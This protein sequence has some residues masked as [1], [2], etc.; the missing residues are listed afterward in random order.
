MPSCSDLLSPFR[1]DLTSRLNGTPILIIDGKKDTRRSS[2]DGALLAECLTRAGATVSH[3]VL[4]VGHS[5][6]AMD[7][8]IA[9]EWLA[10]FVGE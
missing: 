9:R 3:H 8:K 10:T 1:D 4:P 5:V 6:T 2:D 7:R